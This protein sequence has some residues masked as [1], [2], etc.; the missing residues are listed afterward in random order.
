MSLFFKLSI[1][2]F[3]I[4]LTVQVFAQQSNPVPLTKI[5]VKTEKDTVKNKSVVPATGLGRMD[6]SD[7]IG[8]LLNHPPGSEVDSIG[9]KPTISI[10]PA[11]GYTLVSRFAIVLSGNAAFRTG[12]N[13]RISS[14][15]NQYLEQRQCL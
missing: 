8:L 5:P 6:I 7:F 15:T 3:G 2:I 11:I 12:P 13:S 4:L 14:G 1:S 9:A 10:A